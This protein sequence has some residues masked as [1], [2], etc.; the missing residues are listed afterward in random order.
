MNIIFK[1]SVGLGFIYQIATQF[2]KPGGGISSGIEA[3]LSL[4]ASIPAVTALAIAKGLSGLSIPY[5]GASNA[6]I[7]LAICLLIIFSSLWRINACAK[8]RSKKSFLKKI[9]SISALF[10]LLSV[11]YL[12]ESIRS[13]DDDLASIVNGSYFL[14]FGDQRVK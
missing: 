6:S 1:L 3:S 8:S 7:V 11:Y 5:S 4:I 10:I 9:A 13:G 2:D 12:Q 14:I